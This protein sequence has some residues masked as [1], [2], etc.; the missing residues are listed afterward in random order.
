MSRQIEY[1]ELKKRLCI[2]SKVQYGFTDKEKKKGKLLHLCHL[3]QELDLVPEKLHIFVVPC[4]NR[5]Q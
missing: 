3:T 5:N 2:N 1:D 4:G